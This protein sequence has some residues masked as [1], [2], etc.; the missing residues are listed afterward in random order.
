MY[1]SSLEFLCLCRTHEQ[2]AMLRKLLSGFQFES[3]MKEERVQQMAS[4]LRAL[5]LDTPDEPEDAPEEGADA[6]SSEPSGVIRSMKVRVACIHLC[7]K[8]AESSSQ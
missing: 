1:M 7:L 5:M 3:K 6:M 2:V 4:T 8:T